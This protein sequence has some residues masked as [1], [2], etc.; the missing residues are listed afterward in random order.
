MDFIEATD[1]LTRCHT[2]DDIADA[3]GGSLQS[4]RQARMHPSASGY[5]SPPPAWEEAIA[6]LA[7]ERAAELVKL[8]KEL[9]G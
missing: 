6:R 4:I 8:A 1:R 5:R 9:G 3:V 2:H 7:R